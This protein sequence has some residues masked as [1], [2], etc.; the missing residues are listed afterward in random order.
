MTLIV[1][2]IH[3]VN[4][5]DNSIII[6]AADRRVTKN[7][8]YDSTRKKLFSVPM[9][10]GMV[11]YFG[12]AGI[13]K[14]NKLVYFS[15]WVPRIIRVLSASKRC[16]KDF[17]YCFQTE[18]NHFIPEKYLRT[19]P[20]GFHISGFDQN[21]WPD[22][23]WI[24]NINEMD[25]L[26]YKALQRKYKLPES[27]FLN[28]DAK[29]ILG[30]NGK[31]PSKIENKSCGYRSGS[32]EGHIAAWPC[33][34]STIEKLSKSNLFKA[35]K[36]ARNL[37]ERT[38]LQFEVIAYFYKKLAKKKIVA[39]PIDVIVIESKKRHGKTEFKD[40]IL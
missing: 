19:N 34:S 18:L 15:D 38:K 37:C 32:L 27:H 26:E 16:L 6:G 9:I 21:G 36:D 35:K 23:Y 12:L 22:F 25:G 28:R 4:G 31:D 5:L 2:E 10:N 30:W 1:N 40:H 7:G 39:K 29:Q 20:S 3:I 14:N 33:L 17:A 13:Q 24:S 8:Q 11:S